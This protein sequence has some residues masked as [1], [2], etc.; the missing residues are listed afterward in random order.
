[1]RP[2][3]GQGG[4]RS[5]ELGVPEQF[6]DGKRPDK[7]SKCDKSF[8]LKSSL[9]RHWRI[10]TGERPYECEECG[11]SFSQSSTLIIH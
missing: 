7:C 10:H 2:T 6:H 9:I 1:E 8:S 3:L 5:L 4:G 11:K